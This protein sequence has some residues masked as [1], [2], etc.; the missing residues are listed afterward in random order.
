[1][2]APTTLAGADIRLAYLDASG[3]DDPDTATVGAKAANLMRSANAGLLVPSGFVLSTAV[4]ATY[5]TIRRPPRRGRRRA[6]ATGVPTVGEL[7]V[8]ALQA[9]VVRLLDVYRLESGR[10]FPET[11]SSNSPEPSRRCSAP[12][13][14]RVPSSTAAL[15]A[16]SASSTSSARQ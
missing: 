15:S 8:A 13:G 5:E 11:P 1:M 10:P 2:S 14:H 12:G 7:D 3:I 6:R 9:L 16:L 4:C